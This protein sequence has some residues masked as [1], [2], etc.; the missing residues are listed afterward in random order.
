MREKKEKII[1]KCPSGI[2]ALAAVLVLAAAI[3]SP[4][5]YA[6]AE[7]DRMLVPMGQ[8]VG[9]QLNTD[10]VLV[11][12]LVDGEDGG[13]SPAAAAGL[14]PG[15]LITEFNGQKISCADDFRNA[16]AALDGGPVA[17]TADR[18]GESLRM[19]IE[20]RLTEKGTELGLWLRDGITGIGTLTYYDPETGAFG[21]LGHS[22]S[23][24]DSGRLIPMGR[25]H[26]MRS[27]VTDIIRGIAGC[28]GEL[29]GTF[30]E[31][32]ICGTIS[33]N[34]VCGIFGQLSAGIPGAGEAIPVADEDEVKLGA[35]TV[36]ATTSGTDIEEFQIEVVRVYRNGDSNRSMMIKITDPRL[37]ERTGGIVQGMSGSP[38][39]QDGKLIGA[40]THVLI[41]DPAS[42]FAVSIYDMLEASGE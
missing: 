12:G 37:I 7:E 32:G 34:T 28:P 14:L 18:D 38:I 41:N 8:A 33:K 2:R 6:R 20:P 30:D 21:G 27:S 11:V 36:R 19:T 40:V 17:L 42:G 39:I 3:L 16:A 23:D 26:I 13:K 15:D 25:G 29:C 4:Q 31:G 10:G 35:A 9:I 22:V 24:V 1:F 5:A